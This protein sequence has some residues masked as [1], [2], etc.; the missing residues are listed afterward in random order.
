MPVT[1]MGVTGDFYKQSGACGRI[2]LDDDAGDSLPRFWG[3]ILRPRARR[4]R[5]LDL[6][7][8]IAQIVDCYGALASG[9]RIVEVYSYIL[10]AGQFTLVFSP[11]RGA[12]PNQRR[13]RASAY[14]KSSLHRL[15]L[16][17]FSPG[18]RAPR[19]LLPEIIC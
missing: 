18:V 7:R 1:G 13:E 11:R 9:G 6:V 4:R 12:D 16:L 19:C 10:I 15:F 14:S 17:L 5:E 3:D 2:H 8:S